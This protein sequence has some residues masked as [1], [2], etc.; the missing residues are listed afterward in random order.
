MWTL[1]HSLTHSPDDFDFADHGFI[2][3]VFICCIEHDEVTSNLLQLK[4]RLEDFVVV[5]VCRVVTLRITLLS[6]RLPLNL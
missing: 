4:T 3:Q 5:A 2:G 6:S 1:T